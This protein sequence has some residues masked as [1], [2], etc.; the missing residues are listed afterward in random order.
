MVDEEDLYLFEEFLSYME[1]KKVELEKT[2]LGI[3][4]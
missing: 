4:V 1:I 3:L 2:V